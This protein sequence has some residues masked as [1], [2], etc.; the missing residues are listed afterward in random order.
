M[1]I[2]PTSA[3]VL[4]GYGVRDRIQRETEFPVHRVTRIY[5]WEDMALL[6]HVESAMDDVNIALFSPICGG[7]FLYGTKQG[8]LRVCSTFRGDF[9]DEQNCNVLDGPR[10]CHYDQNL[11]DEEED[12]D[13][14][15]EE[16]DDDEDDE[17]DD[18]EEGEE[19]M[20]EDGDEDEDEGNDDEDADMGE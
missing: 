16:E 10:R 1:K 14:G 17:G 3:Y 6:S 9:H 4:L 2:S 13:L 20:D 18:D 11:N 5:R 8:K 19:D 7:G 12:G 15:E